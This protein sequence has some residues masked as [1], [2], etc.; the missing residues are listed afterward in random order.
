MLSYDSKITV[1]TLNTQSITLKKQEKIAEKTGDITSLGY[2]RIS[3]GPLLHSP[4]PLF[5][6][7]F[8]NSLITLLKDGE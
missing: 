8:L 5:C 1:S 2:V 7:D 6:F 4:G 3:P